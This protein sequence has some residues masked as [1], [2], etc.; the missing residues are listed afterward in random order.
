MV[1]IARERIEL[2][3]RE[4]DTAALSG[5]LDMADRY[6][7]MA[8]RVGMRYNV[9]IPREYRRR[10]CRGCY[11]YMLPGITS[12]TRL[13]RGK[14]VTTCTRCGHIARM[15]LVERPADGGDHPEEEVKD[16]GR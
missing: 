12:R 1:L 3:M 10:F 9:R 15:P 16:D 14:L 8:R 4:A 7:E 2:L 13:N 6:V 11:G 5:S